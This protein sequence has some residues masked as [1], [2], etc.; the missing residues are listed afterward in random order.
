MVSCGLRVGCLDF[1]SVEKDSMLM[2][3]A[4]AGIRNRDHLS[5]IVQDNC[6]RSFESLMGS[7]LID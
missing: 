3:S 5:E 1:Q 7:K 4:C 2:V 6:I